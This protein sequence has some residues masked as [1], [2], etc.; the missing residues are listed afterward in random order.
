MRH[1]GRWRKSGCRRWGSNRFERYGPGYRAFEAIRQNQ[2]K[3]VDQLGASDR[4]T[5]QRKSA[6]DGPADRKGGTVTCIAGQQQGRQARVTLP[7]RPDNGK[8]IHPRHGEVRDHGVHRFP[9]RE[10][11]ERFDTVRGG[12]HVVARI[13]Q[14]LRDE[15]SNQLLVIDQ[16]HPGGCYGVRGGDSI[17]RHS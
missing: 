8:A 9:R 1:G 6:A 17:Q 13:L 12:K 5:Q 7:H 10:Q 11:S 2:A 15:L 4:F 16:Q 3:S 14:L